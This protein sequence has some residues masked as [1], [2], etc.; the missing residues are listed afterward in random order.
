MILQIMLT[1][2]QITLKVLRNRRAIDSELAKYYYD[3]SDVLISA[4]DKLLKRNTIDIKSLKSY[5][6]RGD[7][8]TNSTSYKIASAFVEGLKI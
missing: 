6:I 5:K 7:L 8:G 2:S 3:L 4:L 1:E